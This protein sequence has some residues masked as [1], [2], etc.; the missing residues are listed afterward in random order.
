MDQILQSSACGPE[1]L[2]KS[3][4]AFDRAFA[5]QLLTQLVDS[6]CCAEEATERALLPKHKLVD[7]L[8]RFLWSWGFV[9][10]PV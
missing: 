8:I 10:R 2:L 9:K 6:G 5:V 3:A 7:A 4:D 1:H